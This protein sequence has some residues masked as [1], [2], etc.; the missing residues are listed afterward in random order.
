[1]ARQIEEYFAGRRTRV[2]P[3]AGSPLSSGFH[4]QVLGRLSDVPVT[5]GRPAT[6]PSRRRWRP[7]GGTRGRHGVRDQSVARC[8]P[9]ATVWCGRTEPG[10]GTPAAA[11]IKDVAHHGGRRLTLPVRA[12]EPSKPPAPPKPPAPSNPRPR[13]TPAPSNPGPRPT[14]DPVQPDVTPTPSNPPT[15]TGTLPRVQG[16]FPVR[17]PGAPR[18]RP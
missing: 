15:R 6:R 11:D 14:P 10:A 5:A 1:M 18:S 4:R 13:P 16:T 17:G 9:R 3:R 8:H 12:P 2:R 7:Q